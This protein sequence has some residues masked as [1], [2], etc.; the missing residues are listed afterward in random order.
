MGGDAITAVRPVFKLDSGAGAGKETLI[1]DRYLNPV[2]FG[3]PPSMAAGGAYYLGKDGM[4]YT[5]D[6]TKPKTIPVA[7]YYFKLSD[8]VLT[9][10]ELEKLTR[11]DVQDLVSLKAVASQ[12]VIL[13]AAV[14]DLVFIM[15]KDT[16]PKKQFYTSAER[17]FLWEVGIPAAWITKPPSGSQ[18]SLEEVVDDLAARKS[19]FRDVVIISHANLH[20][21]LGFPLERGKTDPV[22]YQ[23]LRAKL[24]AGGWSDASKTVTNKVVI[25]GCNIGQ[26]TDMM[27][28][29]AR[30]F[31]G[32]CT[33]YAPTHK[34]NY[35]WFNDTKQKPPKKWALE[36]FW[37]FWVSYSGD[38]T[39]SDAEL[40]NDFT[41]KYPESDAA[42]LKTWIADRNV[43][44]RLPISLHTG[45]SK[46]S[47]HPPTL[48]PASEVV[49]WAKV[50]WK[51]DFGNFT[52]TGFVKR[53]KKDKSYEYMFEGT[54]PDGE[55]TMPIE[56]EFNP[57]DAE[58]LKDEKVQHPDVT[59]YDWKVQRTPV[60][61]AEEQVRTT[62]KM[63]VY[64][65]KQGMKDSAGQY[66]KAELTNTKYWG[67]SS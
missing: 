67:S 4:P 6:K 14:P 23:T 25:R 29:M 2:K 31:G 1:S 47:L 20:G 39:K 51:S 61:A 19:K 40:G 10:Q 18:M 56:V 28:L 36:Y 43:T 11:G 26:S 15:G 55:G 17:Y 5:E 38:V 7:D 30:A 49:K 16:D 45:V 62:A 34:Q 54:T 42:Q 53:T 50:H 27:K 60:G 44:E 22:V 59:W 57:D 13:T 52:P 64:R 3:S 37:G 33:L 9:S 63:T 8:H 58:V 66:I 35:E 48:T 12:T 41:S 46:F 65:I 24:A 21:W 32:K